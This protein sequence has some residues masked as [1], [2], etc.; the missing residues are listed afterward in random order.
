MAKK[1]VIVE[2]PAKVKTI[3]KFLGKDYEITSS[4]GHIRDLPKSAS[5]SKAA[6][7]GTKTAKTAPKKTAHEKFIAR[8]GIDPDHN[9]QAN[10]QIIP[11]KEKVVAELKAAAKRC[12]Q[13]IL[14]TD[15]DREGEAIA[16]HLR[17]M[18]GGDDA[19]YQ[20]IVFNEITKSAIEA[21]LATPRS[22]NLN[23]VYA[24]QARRF[25]DRV[26]G[27]LISPLLWTRIARGLS[28]GRVQSVALRLLCDREHAIQ[29]FVPEEFWTVDASLLHQRAAILFAVEKYQGKK[30]LPVNKAECDQHLARLNHANYHLAD[31]IE[32]QTQVRPHAPLITSTLQQ[33]ASVRLGFGVK[34]TM[35][36]A[37]KLYEA[38]FITYMR[39]DS[40]NLSKD[41]IKA[42]RDY[43][44]EQFGTDYLPNTPNLYAKRQNA[45]EAHE[46]IRPTD[47]FVQSAGK[48]KDEMALYQLIHK[49][50]VAC[51]MLPVR[52]FT[53][54]LIAHGDDKQYRLVARG[55]KLIFDGFTRVMPTK[56]SDQILPDISLNSQLALDKL[57]DKQHFTKPPARFTEASLVKELERRS[58]GRPSTYV[59]IISTL[60]QREYVLLEQKKFHVQKIGEIVSSWL[61]NSFAD[62]MRY[63]F[64]ADMEQNLDKIS[65]GEM[66]WKEL[67]DGFYQQLQ[68]TIQQVEQQTDTSLTAKIVDIRCVKCDSNMLL[69]HGSN[70]LFLGCSNYGDKDNPCKTTLNLQKQASATDNEED[71]ETLLHSKRCGKCQSTMDSH[72]VADGKHK[73]WLCSAYP[74]C[75]EM[76]LETGTFDLGIKTIDCYKCDGSMELKSGRFGQYYA[77]DGCGQTRKAQKDGTPAP[78][79]MDPITMAELKC[80]K[81]DD[82]YILREGAA[83]LFLAA[84]KYPKHREARSP[85]VKEIASLKSQLEPRLQ[86]LC[87]APIAD[88][89]GND[90]II[91]FSKKNIHHYVTSMH[92]GKRTKWRMIYDLVGRSWVSDS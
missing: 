22:L 29:R 53:T 19:N 23:Q 42:V 24:Q 40:V 71:A 66:D 58:I 54:Q 25:L 6:K 2:S 77:C 21:A 47:V 80:Q 79:R 10:Y 15:L 11:G 48:D 3:A 84:S 62:L 39:T 78:V 18:I 69:R 45:Q 46:A 89:K 50:F 8:L 16:W 55:R 88:P 28:A 30:F 38:G 85:L 73:L 4:V 74:S 86:Y 59:P 5:A 72:V 35:T 87:D 70:G 26:A 63:E 51:Q 36:L 13:I 57:T 76:E 64:T 32:K 90:S 52:Y 61:Q 33:A 60:Q 9:W 91:A 56:D 17:E 68:Q 92:E 44:E 67:L 75:S 31:K 65:Q 7:S 83:G 37:Q 41:A 1:L 34:K 12:D 14:A 27:F 43:I 82:H 20:R 49:Q 81:V